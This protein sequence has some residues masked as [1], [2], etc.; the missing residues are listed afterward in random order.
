MRPNVNGAGEVIGY[1][2]KGGNDSGVASTFTL[3]VLCYK[4]SARVSDRTGQERGQP[5]S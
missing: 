3:Y 2:A 4:G 5:R 1:T